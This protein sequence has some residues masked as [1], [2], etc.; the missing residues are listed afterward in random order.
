MTTD[1]LELP[2]TKRLDLLEQQLR[3]FKMWTYLF[4]VVILMTTV[5]FATPWLRGTMSG[6]A[7]FLKNRHGDVVVSLIAGGGTG[8]PSLLLSDAAGK[9]RAWL[10]STPNGDTQ[11]TLQDAKGQQRC[12]MMIRNDD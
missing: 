8:N 3:R 10:F 2:I 12:A 11:L 6:N 4:G 9:A 1:A 7:V 5:T